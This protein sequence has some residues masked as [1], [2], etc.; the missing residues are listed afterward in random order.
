MASYDFDMGIIGGG[1]A[2]LTVAAGSGQLGARTL[3]VEREPSLGGDCLHYGC[4]PSKALIASASLY[5]RMG[6][7]ERLGLPPVDLP[8]VDFV[9]IA[10]RI[11]EVQAVIQRHD[12]VER[13]CGLGVRVEFGE[14]HFIDDHVVD[15]GGRRFSARSWLVATGSS[16]APPPFP[17]ADVVP[18]L[19]NREIF[20]LDALP[21]S[22]IVLG[23]GP[24]ACELA[25]AFC[26]LGSNVR[27]VQR[28]PQ[29][30]SREDADMADIVRSTLISE[31]VECHLGVTVREVRRVGAGVEVTIVDAQGREQPLAA[32]ALFVALG[33]SANVEGLGLDHAGVT[34][35]RRGVPVDSRMRTSQPHIYAAG[36][37]TGHH[38]FTHAAGYEGGIV[39]SNAIFRIP[40]RADYAHL[41]WC[42]YTRPEFA[43]IGLNEKRAAAQGLDVEVIIEDFATNDR[44]IAE[45]EA[46]GRI[47]LLL[48][49][50]RPVGVQIVGPS[51]GD[52]IAEWVAIQN[53]GV[54]LSTLA[55]AV[56]PYPTFAEINKRVAGS[57]LG[58]RIFSDKVRRTLKLF[59]NY[60]GNACTLGKAVDE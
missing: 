50:G 59:F 9:R 35:D 23:G 2:G 11:R 22:M 27:I 16:A 57:Y 5:H 29:L 14:A 58:P 45:D 3:L 37:V 60:K 15:V 43:S 17:G 24:I 33:R 36:D 52:L 13:F 19:T 42:T 28:S 30:L 25:Q 44:A 26:R 54:R 56:H 21:A 10:A 38:Q 48:H 34:H 7:P 49:R 20:F 12:S 41:P 31:G 47:K 51:A 32:D 53:G 1:A 46:L 39:V 18:F 40:R 8:P 4:V 6:H 55:G